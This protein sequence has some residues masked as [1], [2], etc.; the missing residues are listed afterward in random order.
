VQLSVRFD[1]PVF[2]TGATADRPFITI[3]GFTNGEI[4]RR[5]VYA[6]GSGTSTLVFRYRVVAG[7]KALAG[8]AY[9]ASA[10][11]LEAA[12]LADAAGNAA[13]LGFTLP[14]RRPLTKVNA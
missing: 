7:D 5:A 14:S 2:V 13:A 10:I 3:G 1:R 12:S 11:T 8:I 4:T 9:S 6:S